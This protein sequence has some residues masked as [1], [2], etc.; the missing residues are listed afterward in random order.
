[1]SIKSMIFTAATKVKLH[2]P[3]ILLVGGIAAIVGGTVA[4]CISTTKLDE[5]VDDA[6][7]KLEIIRDSADNEIISSEEAPKLKTQCYLKTAARVAYLYSI[8]TLLIGAGITSILVSHK[9]MS[10][11]MGVLTTALNSTTALF[12]RYR[13]NVI[14]KYGQNVDYDMINNRYDLTP[15]QRA[16]AESVDALIKEERDMPWI[17]KWDRCFDEGNP[18][19]TKDA[20][21]NEAFLACNE[22]YL[23]D[24]MRSRRSEKLLKN[25]VVKVIP[26]YILASEVDEALGWTRPEDVK[27]YAT[28]IGK[29]T[30]GACDPSQPDYFDLG[31]FERD[32]RGGKHLV[33][34]DRSIW[35]H[36]NYD[37]YIA[38]LIGV[39]IYF[40]YGKRCDKDGNYL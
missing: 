31:I 2:S 22:N 25:G 11:R 27:P 3:A 35:I 16:E 24:K 14:A 1:M 21:V 6:K 8:P 30:D 28:S 7:S 12:N 9:I 5:V 10:K 26:G 33:I 17:E 38:E 32:E 37:G 34:E 39:P 20:Y 23:N 19:W 18:N 15:S 13:R 4:A 40:K 29:M 36:P